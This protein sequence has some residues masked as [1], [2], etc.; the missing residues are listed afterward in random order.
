[1]DGSI[2]AIASDH[3]PHHTDE[4]LVEFD[5]APFGII[6]LETTVPLIL[7]RLVRTKQLTPT[8]F[9]ELLAVNP[10]RIL[11]LRKGRLQVGDDADITLID[12]EL[13]RKVDA[14]QF[15]SK[16]RNTPFQGYS[17][18][19]WPLATLVGGRVVHEQLPVAAR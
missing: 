15:L 18:R 4:K 6:G 10:A 14:S 12:P 16:S 9:V 8:R 3:A 11:G 13:E 5:E 1:M 17:L 19:G 2:D 7:D